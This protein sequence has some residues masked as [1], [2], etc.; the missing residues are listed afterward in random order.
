MPTR[1]WFITGASRGFGRVFAEAALDRGDRVAATARHPEAL[2]DLE[3]RFPDTALALPLDVTDHDAAF[4]AVRRAHEHFGALDVVVNNAGYGLFGFAE[5]ASEQEARRQLETNFFGT[6]WV[7]QAALPIMRAQRRG[8]IV[9]ISSFGGIVAVPHFSMYVA[10]KWAV[11]GF[12]DVLGQEMANF[13]VHVTIVEP[14]GYATD[15]GHGSA[16]H[17]AHLPA[18]DAILP[19][20]WGEGGFDPS[21]A[22]PALL[23][24]VD[25]DR[26]PRRVA[27]GSGLV[28][29]FERVYTQRLLEWRTWER[30]S[31]AA[32]GSVR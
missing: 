27:F 20:P 24:I 26:P 22:G 10:S 23:A 14:G 30:I 29:I 31:D 25:A 21:A 11:E 16:A 6:V 15:W 12:S 18:Y 3:R 7:S 1:T 13:G 28:D 17:S 5:E 4:D 19:R 32:G 9:Q 8:H 2:H